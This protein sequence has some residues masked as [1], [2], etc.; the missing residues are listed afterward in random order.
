MFVQGSITYNIVPLQGLYLEIAGPTLPDLKHKLGVNYEEI[1]RT[2]VAR[3]IGYFL[4]SAVAGVAADFFPRYVR[5]R[6]LPVVGRAGVAA[7]FFP[8]YV[9]HR[10]LPVIG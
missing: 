2:L 10:L 4:S 3:S 1:A 6:L 7:D 8:L 5:H 9:R